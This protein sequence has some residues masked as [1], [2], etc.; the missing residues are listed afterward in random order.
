MK[1]G[2]TVTEEPD[3][4]SYALKLVRLKQKLMSDFIQHDLQ[5]YVLLENIGN[6]GIQEQ[7]DRYY[8]RICE[9]FFSEYGEQ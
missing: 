4:L 9:D 6:T 3:N 8:E 7:I 5:L 1:T 2:F